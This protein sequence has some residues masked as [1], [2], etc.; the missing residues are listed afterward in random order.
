MVMV[1][2]G[3]LMSLGVAIGLGFTAGLRRRLVLVGTVVVGT[4]GASL[5]LWYVER[6]PPGDWLGLL[7][8]CVVVFAAA[9]P[10]RPSNE[11]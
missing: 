3:L 4:V 2:A 5:W 10:R 1:A 6:Q 7:V 8:L 9:R 11:S